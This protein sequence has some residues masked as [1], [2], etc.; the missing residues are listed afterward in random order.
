MTSTARTIGTSI[1][2]GTIQVDTSR[3]SFA[4]FNK[5]ATAIL[6]IKEGREVSV[7]NGIPVYPKGNISL[8]Y[9]ED[10]ETVRESWSMISDTVTTPIIIFEGS[11]K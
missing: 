8:N 2:I 9:V 10:G 7:D 4:I 5:H 3:L 11:K 1:D 6:Y